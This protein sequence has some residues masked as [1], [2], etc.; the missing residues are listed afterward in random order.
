MSVKPTKKFKS[1]MRSMGQDMRK[2]P[3]QMLPSINSWA[4]PASKVVAMGYQLSTSL[5]V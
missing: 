5:G 2:I 4:G 3:F 1:M